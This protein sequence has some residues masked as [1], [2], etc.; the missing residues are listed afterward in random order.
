MDMRKGHLHCLPRP[1]M[2]CTVKGTDLRPR[3]P[4]QDPV[5]IT[6]RRMALQLPMALHSQ[7]QVLAM[8][9]PTRDLVA[10]VVW[11]LAEVWDL[12]VVWDLVLATV[13]WALAMAL[14]TDAMLDMALATD[15]MLVMV[16]ATAEMLALVSLTIMDVTTVAYTSKTQ[17]KQQ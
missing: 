14:A 6:T 1:I 2:A 3:D 17:K 15:A 12:A 9:V 13:A 7:D 5:L 16:L 10:T 8:R 4:L 11:D